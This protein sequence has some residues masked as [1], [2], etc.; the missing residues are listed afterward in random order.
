MSE[1]I[2]YNELLAEACKKFNLPKK[3][4]DLL[5]AIPWNK[6]SDL[7]V[8]VPKSIFASKENL[9]RMAYDHPTHLVFANIK[10]DKIEFNG[11][12]QVLVN[13]T[14]DSATIKTRGKLNEPVLKLF[15][16][17]IYSEKA[18]NN[19]LEKAVITTSKGKKINGYTNANAGFP[20]ASTYK[21]KEGTEH[22]VNYFVSI[23][24]ETNQLDYVDTRVAEAYIDSQ[25]Q[26]Y[27]VNFTDQQKADLKMGKAVVLFDCKTIENGKEKK[28]NCAVQYNATAGKLVPCQPSWLKEVI[29]NS[30]N[31][32]QAVE[33]KKE[34]KPAVKKTATKKAA[35]EGEAKKEVK[36]SP[37]K[38]VN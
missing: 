2:K 32:A 18:V 12:I 6:V 29:R 37:R 25:K 19:L 7:G 13:H 23:D 33:V 38:K 24:P 36:K 9:E 26:M 16:K 21:D 28:F 30:N 27:G 1:E 15:G 35:A 34:E 20:I 8:D 17:D 3:T 11:E 5:S 14:K 22:T 4:Q 10:N 31:Q